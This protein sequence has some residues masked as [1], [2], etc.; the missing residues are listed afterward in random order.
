MVVTVHFT[1]R[2]AE[3]EVLDVADGEDPLV[4]LHGA[5]NVPPGLEDALVGKKV[6][7]KFEVRVSPE[8]GFGEKTGEVARLPRKELPDEVEVGDE[9]ELED[10]EGEVILCFVSA[11]EPDAVVVTP[12]HP[13]AG[14]TL[15]YALEVVDVRP[16]SREELAHGHPH[17][18]GGHVH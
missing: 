17:G 2:N 8:M 5:E 13:L 1:L 12:D 9:L 10:D 18:P 6:G 11:V 4:Y 14:V 7:D 15:C 16:A 3:G